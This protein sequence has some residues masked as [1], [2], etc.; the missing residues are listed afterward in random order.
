MWVSLHAFQVEGCSNSVVDSRALVLVY[1]PLIELRTSRWKFDPVRAASERNLLVVVRW[2]LGGGGVHCLLRSPSLSDSF[3]RSKQRKRWGESSERKKRSPS[4]EGSVWANV[5]RGGWLETVSIKWPY[6]IDFL[7]HI[8]EMSTGNHNKH[9][10]LW[11]CHSLI[12]FCACCTAYTILHSKLGILLY[13]KYNIR[14]NINI[15]SSA[16]CAPIE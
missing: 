2:G 3:F 4:G 15:E 12:V 16:K 11:Y 9:T 6:E 10:T 13:W 14:T 7:D 8:T 1:F 5:G